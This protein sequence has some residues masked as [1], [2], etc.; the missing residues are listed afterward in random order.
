MK[1]PF[2]HLVFCMA[3]ITQLLPRQR[4]RLCPLLLRRQ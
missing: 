1:R 4:Q 2:L 3:S